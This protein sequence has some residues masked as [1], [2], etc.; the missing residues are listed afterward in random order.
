M[1]I[2]I[3]MLILNYVIHSWKKWDQIKK[4]LN[5][6]YY[7]CLLCFG[8]IQLWAFFSLW[9]RSLQADSFLIALF[10][11]LVSRLLFDR[12]GNSTAFQVH[13]PNQSFHLSFL[14]WFLGKLFF[15]ICPVASLI[16]IEIVSP[17]FQANFLC[18]C[19]LF[20]WLVTY[21]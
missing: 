8:S 10:R 20:I 17:S 13:F 7:Y 9:C 6:F 19:N 16:E 14:G 5:I 11:S 4:Y 15:F 3:F 18:K 21:F 12:D 1:T 2:H